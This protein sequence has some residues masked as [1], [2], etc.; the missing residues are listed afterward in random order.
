MAII[1]CPECGK[2]ISDRAAS[3]PNCGCPISA[4]PTEILSA[5]SN[6]ATI[7][8]YLT[9]ATSAL[10]ASNNEEADSYASKVLELDA[11]NARAWMIKG[12]GIGWQSTVSNVRFDEMTNCWGK[13]LENASEVEAAEFREVMSEQGASLVKALVNVN[14]N[15]FS[16]YP[17]KDNLNH[18][19]GCANTFLSTSVSLITH[20]VKVD[21]AEISEYMASKMN[22]A[23][24][25]GS[26][27]ADKNYG[28]DRSDKH[29]YAYRRWIDENDNCISLLETALAMAEEEST[30]NRIVENLRVL[31]ENAINS[32]CY[33]FEANGYTSGYYKDQSLTET[34][35]SNR[36]KEINK[37]KATAKD[38]I[39][40]KKDAEEKKRREEQEKRNKEYWDAH[41]EERAKLEVQKNELEAKIQPINKEL[42]ELEQQLKKAQEEGKIPVAAIAEK[43]TLNKQIDSLIE[44]KNA[45]GLFK[46]KEKK[47]LQAQIDEL[48]AQLPIVNQRIKDQEK[49]REEKIADKTAPISAKISTLSK[50][51]R[52][53]NS[54]L[55][56]VNKELTKDR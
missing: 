28:P 10:D 42:N 18:L 55:D 15:N 35:K 3:C 33:K 54:E 41:A 14:A 4:A 51:K 1:S 25:A 5:Q 36:R 48:N 52:E 53:I 9:L 50:Q 11:N 8:N 43:K 12:V 38:K 40:K 17:S 2:Q 26:D 6:A 22:Q 21:I 31:Q 19:R 7:E 44:Q 56:K 46:G 24:V 20:G 34:A 37:Y 45:L 49:E 27:V 23:A 47:A 32:C 30:I 16:S 13:C 29:I 39:K